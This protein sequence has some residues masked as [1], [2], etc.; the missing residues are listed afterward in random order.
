MITI[1]KERNLV[2]RLIVMLILALVGGYLSYR[3][4]GVQIQFIT[5]DDR[6]SQGLDN[7][8][9][10]LLEHSLQHPNA[11]RF[12]L[13][14]TSFP[15]VEQLKIKQVGLN[16]I[17][18]QVTA[19]DLRYRLGSNFVLTSS[20]QVFLASC[21][22]N[23]T[24]R[25]LPAIFLHTSPEVASEIEPEQIKFLLNLSDDLI[26]DY[27]VHWHG[28]N[29]INLINRQNN[30]Y[31]IVIRYDQNLTL[32]LLATCHKLQVAYVALATKKCHG[33]IKADLRFH[34]QIIMAC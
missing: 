16:K 21:F 1:L 2:L 24:I 7:A 33:I 18:V 29:Q 34:K 31:Q 22:S 14:K 17:H 10:A 30:H 20:G 3:A 13:L 6:L 5:G 25:N 32:D 26:A 23:Q 15:V 28:L 12:E 27:E 9:K 19:A 8:I 11:Q 4:Q